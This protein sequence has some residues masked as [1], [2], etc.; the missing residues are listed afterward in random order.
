MSEVTVADVTNLALFLLEAR[1]IL[2][3]IINSSVL[4]AIISIGDFQ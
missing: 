3:I 1:K 2:K 4:M